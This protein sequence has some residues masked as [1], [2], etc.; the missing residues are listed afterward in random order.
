MDR[1]L[2]AVISQKLLKDTLENIK[3]ALK[4]QFVSVNHLLTKEDWEEINC[5]AQFLTI[6]IYIASARTVGVIEQDI[7]SAITGFM[8]S[9]Q[10]H[11]SDM[12]FF[13]Q[14]ASEY[15]PLFNP[16]SPTPFASL[17]SH[18]MGHLTVNTEGCMVMLMMWT[19]ELFDNTMPIIASSLSPRKLSVAHKKN[20]GGG[21]LTIM[22]VSC[23]LI[24]AL[25]FLL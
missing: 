5:Y 8:K 6:S 2:K 19:N 14:R 23:L 4:Y 11:L 15:T 1:T 17:S 10:D 20:G 24:F 22:V 7:Q 12:L 3:P 9:E 13:N 25:F 18:F 16:L 21:C